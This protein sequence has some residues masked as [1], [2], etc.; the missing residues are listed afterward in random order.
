MLFRSIETAGEELLD[1]VV[2]VASGEVQ[3]RAVGLGQNDFIPWKQG[4]S[5]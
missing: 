4:I 5:L 2:R 3:P 1:L